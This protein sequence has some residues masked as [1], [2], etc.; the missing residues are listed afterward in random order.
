MRGELAGWSERVTRVG[1]FM[2]YRVP[3]LLATGRTH[4]LPVHEVSD[5][6]VYA[7]WDTYSSFL[8]IATTSSGAWRDQ[9]TVY[10]SPNG[11]R[12]FIFTD[13]YGCYNHHTGTMWINC[14]HFE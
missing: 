14:E 12:F 11:Y 3:V 2:E 4:C 6:V 10:N 13:K 5:E 8:A 1:V 9:S 7:S